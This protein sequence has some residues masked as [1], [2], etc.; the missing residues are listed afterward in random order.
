MK[1][2]NL[3]YNRLEDRESIEVRESTRVV[4]GDIEKRAIVAIFYPS[5]QFC[6]INISL[7]SLQKQPNTAPN[8]FQRGVVLGDIEKRAGPLSQN[9]ENMALVN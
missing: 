7:M 6:E 1:L 5:S 2:N 8:L 9:S 3:M 4:L